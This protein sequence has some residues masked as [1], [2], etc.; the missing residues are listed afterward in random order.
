M[1]DRR[2]HGWTRWLCGCIV[3]T[4]GPARGSINRVSAVRAEP[5]GLMLAFKPA[6]G[7]LAGEFYE[8]NGFRR[9]ALR[10]PD[11]EDAE[12]IRLLNGAGVRA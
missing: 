7:V 12:T 6:P 1:R 8:A 10:A 3:R 2:R 4:S 11:A 9:I 5:G